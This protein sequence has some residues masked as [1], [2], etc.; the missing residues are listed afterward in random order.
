RAATRLGIDQ[1]AHVRRVPETLHTC[2][3]GA[4]D[5]CF[6][7]AVLLDP[8]ELRGLLASDQG[9]HG[10]PGYGASRT[11]KRAPGVSARRA[12]RGATPRASAEDV[13]RRTR[14]SPRAGPVRRTTPGAARSAPPPPLPGAPPRQRAA[15][16]GRACFLAARGARCPRACRQ[17]R[18]R[19]PP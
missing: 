12:R 3:P 2:L 19:P 6:D 11:T 14:A 18:E 10:P 4:L 5:E 16:R 15:L 17:A 1:R 13:C 7:L 8:T 9:L